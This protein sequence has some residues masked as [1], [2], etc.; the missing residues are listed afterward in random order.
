VRARTAARR[1]SSA[2]ASARP[3]CFAAL[4]AARDLRV[5]DRLARVERAGRG[6]M[7]LVQRRAAALGVAGAV[8]LTSSRRRRAA[9]GARRATLRR[10]RGSRPTAAP[11]PTTNDDDD[12]GVSRRRARLV[13]HGQPD[14][15]AGPH[16][17][18]G[19]SDVA[20]CA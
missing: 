18:L 10:A 1:R 3:T 15:L 9:S 8:A 17:L 11:G 2:T 7:L 20:R 5:G 13:A 16:R 19:R 12:D 4:L 6:P 14:R